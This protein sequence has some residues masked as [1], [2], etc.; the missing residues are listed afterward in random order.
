[1]LGF[2][3]WLAALSLAAG[4]VSPK[5][6]SQ[7]SRAIATQKTVVTPRRMELDV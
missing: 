5:A 1:M 6:L 3:D 2:E 4:L 7:L